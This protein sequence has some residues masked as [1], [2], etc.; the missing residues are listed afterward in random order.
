MGFNFVI[1]SSSDISLISLYI[2]LN[3]RPVKLFTHPK[4]LWQS[5]SQDESTELV[6]RTW[7]RSLAQVAI[8][9]DDRFAA[10]D[11]SKLVRECGTRTAIK[12]DVCNKECNKISLYTA[13][14]NHKAVTAYFS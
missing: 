9:R 6:L 2:S 5:I 7:A 4:C 1:M 3:R 13:E 12:T 14:Q 10:C 11:T 8:Y